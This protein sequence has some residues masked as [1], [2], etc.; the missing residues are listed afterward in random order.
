RRPAEVAP[1]RHCRT[2]GAV[3]LTL[4]VALTLAALAVIVAGLVPVSCVCATPTASAITVSGGSVPAVALKRTDALVP[5][6]LLSK[7]C[8]TTYTWPALAPRPFVALSRIDVGMGSNWIG[9]SDVGYVGLSYA[10]AATTRQRTPTNTFMTRTSDRAITRSRRPKAEHRSGEA[11]PLLD[12]RNLRRERQL[13]PQRKPPVDLH[14]AHGE[15]RAD[16]ILEFA[17]P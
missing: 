17:E 7:T 10:Q 2:A 9:T 8:A 16:D 15:L 11:R 14:H 1:G 13:V 6:P 12:Q 3:G 5:W 4:I